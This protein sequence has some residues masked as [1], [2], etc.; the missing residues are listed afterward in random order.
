MRI[1]HDTEPRQ[2]GKSLTVGYE[3]LHE[4]RYLCHCLRQPL[5]DLRQA[6]PHPDQFPVE[7]CR[8]RCR[9]AHSLFPTLLPVAAL[10]G[11]TA[12][13]PM[14]GICHCLLT[15]TIQRGVRQYEGQ[16]VSKWSFREEKA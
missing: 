13:H 10:S 6:L 5:L 2:G 3:P 4:F 12:H 1:C 14:W 11:A 8:I 7:L 16:M 9:D 15:R